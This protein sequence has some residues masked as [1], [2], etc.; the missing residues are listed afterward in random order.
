MYATRFQSKVERMYFAYDT[1]ADFE[2]LIH[3]GK[4]LRDGGIKN[5][6]Y[7]VMKTAKQ[8]KIGGSFN[9]YGCVRRLF[10]TS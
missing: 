10:T 2:P 8:T 4:L 1:P 9:D 5:T 6:C 3:A 7:F